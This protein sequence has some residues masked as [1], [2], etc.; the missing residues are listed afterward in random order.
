MAWVQQLQG[1]LGRSR[2]IVLA[3]LVAVIFFTAGFIELAVTQRQME[4]RHQQALER[5][6][7]TAR[8]NTLLQ[9]QLERAQRDELVPWLAWDLFGRLPKGAGG[10]QTEPAAPVAPDGTQPDQPE[11]PTWRTWLKELGLN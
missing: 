3:L 9:I 5:Y 10:V 2:V 8:Q 1:A 11:Q 6:E 4:A 7:R